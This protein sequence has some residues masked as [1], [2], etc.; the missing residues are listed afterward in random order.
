MDV[1]AEAISRN[2]LLR[3]GATSTD[4]EKQGAVPDP[5][6]AGRTSESSATRLL[7]EV[8]AKGKVEG[9]GIVP[10]PIEDRTSTRYFNVFTI[11]FSMNT[12]IL[13]ITFGLLGPSY[14]LG[15]RDS[16]LVILFFTL[17][18]SVLPAYLGTLGPKTGMRQMIQARFSFGSVTFPPRWTDIAD[19]H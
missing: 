13:A 1:R 15:L 11:W 3:P 8:L 7:S 19:L 10:L 17:L 12:N 6:L 18:A 4:V 9:H 14:G 2:E 5:Q 16:A